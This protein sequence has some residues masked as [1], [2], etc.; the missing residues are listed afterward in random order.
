MQISDAVLCSEMGVHFS[1]CGRFLAATT[2]CRG[3][4]PAS[5]G[6]PVGGEMGCVGEPSL[7]TTLPPGPATLR[8]LS[9]ALR[10][11]ILPG[12]PRQAAA[13]AAGAAQPM[14][15]DTSPDGGEQQLAAADTSLRPER[16][17]FEVRQISISGSTLGQVLRAKR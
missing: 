13:A 6:G 1:P 12:L 8:D 14:L 2:A 10:A 9:A 3:P 5:V 17:V 16:V 7:H 4:L 15:M 11:G